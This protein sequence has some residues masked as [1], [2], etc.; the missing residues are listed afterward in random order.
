MPKILLTRIDNRLVHGQVGVTWVRDLG[1]NLIVVANDLAS[2]DS[3]QQSLMTTTAKS[4][5]VGIRFFSVQHTIDVIHK[6]SDKQLI[7]LVVANAE[8]ARKLVDGGVP[9]DKLNLGNL[10]FAPGKTEFT[11]K[12]Y[13]NDEDKE[14]L[15][16]L[17]TKNIRIYAQDVPTDKVFEY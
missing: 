6:A 9:I 15:D 13:L 4:S 10:H 8:D 7:F 16:Y 5:N 1:A 17:K 2:K 11:K 14:N 3:L 12:V